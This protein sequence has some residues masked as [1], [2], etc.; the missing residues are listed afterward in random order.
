MVIGDWYFWV[1]LLSQS[2]ISF[3]DKEMNKCRFH[4]K[5]TSTDQSLDLKAVWELYA[6]RS[7]IFSL[8]NP[9]MDAREAWRSA[10]Y[11]HWLSKL[12]RSD[13]EFRSF[14]NIKNLYYASIF[15]SNIMMRL[16]KDFPNIDFFC[17]KD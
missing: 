12:M 16:K 10:T 11:K 5:K 15:D 9:T 8:K 2:I 4:S 6:I 14:N 13:P 17:D 3:S 7:L 1:T